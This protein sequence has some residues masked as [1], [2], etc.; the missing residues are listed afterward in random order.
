MIISSLCIYHIHRTFSP[1][2]VGSNPLSLH[3]KIRTGKILSVF[4][5]AEGNAQFPKHYCAPTVDWLHSPVSFRCR[6]LHCTQF[7]FADF[8][9]QNAHGIFSLTS[10]GSNPLSL[11]KKIRTGKI[12]SV[13][14]M[15]EGMGF[16]P[17]GLLRLT[18]VPGELLSHSVNPLYHGRHL[19]TMCYYIA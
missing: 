15:A 12:L 9:A 4:L 3:K 5:M 19:T 10:V 8:R 18:R 17:T 14:L 11:H 6:I 7:R 16:E 13:F 2:P 1:T